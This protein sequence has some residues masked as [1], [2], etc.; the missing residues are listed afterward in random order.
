[1]IE[2]LKLMTIT[3]EMNVIDF[4]THDSYKNNFDIDV[5]NDFKIQRSMMD[6]SLWLG[7]IHMCTL[8]Q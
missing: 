2:K 4:A 5:L 1:M 8:L 3:I 6:Q 7:F